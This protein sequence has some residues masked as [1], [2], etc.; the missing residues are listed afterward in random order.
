MTALRNKKYP[1]YT[2]PEVRDMKELLEYCATVYG[3]KT[4]I[5]FRKKGE[6]IKLS[7]IHI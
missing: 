7:L 6:V 2:V 1:Y 4:A 5:W 3:E